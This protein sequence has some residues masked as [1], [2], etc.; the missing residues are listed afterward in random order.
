T[1]GID[2]GTTSVKAVAAGPDGQILERVRVPHPVLVPGADRL[3]HDADRAWRRGP[4]RALA[5]LKGLNPEAVAISTM[6]PS[7]TAVDARG[8]PLSPG[9][10]Y[11]DARGRTGGVERRTDS[12]AG[13]V[14][15]FLRWTAAEVPG[16]TGYWPA[17]AVANYALGRQP[18]IDIGTAFTSSPL[19]G[20]DGWDADLCAGIG[21]DVAQLPRVEMM[22]S[23]IGRVSGAD[24]MLA[25]GS[26]DGLCEQLVSGAD[27]PGDVLVIC[28]TTLIVWLV[29]DEPQKAEGLWT[30]PH[31]SRWAVGGPSNAGGLFI[32]WAEGLLSRKAG[33]AERLDPADVPVWSPYIRGERSPLHDPDRRAAL[34]GLNLTHGPAAVR[35]A[36]WEAAG[37]VTRHML[38]LAGLPARRLVATGGGTRVDGWMQ[39]LAD[40]TGLPVHVAEVAEGA[41]LGAAYLARM[42]LGAETGFEGAGAWARTGRVVDPHPA[43]T[44]AASDRY[45]LFRTLASAPALVT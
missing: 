15:G 4:R 33:G 16:A 18:V 29:T 26:V 14:V 9:L 44:S 10:L 27:E 31:G 13:E 5:R 17:P 34:H 8:R 23:P 42:A 25:G 41:A 21:V 28:G 37:F 20:G 3:E 7:M 45:R 2:I 11:G 12:D 1:V 35:R 22:G 24:I 38:D 30:I 19:F 40:C 39:A 36:A 32:G 43:W 6:V